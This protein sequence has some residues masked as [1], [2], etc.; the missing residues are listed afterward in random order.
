M[1][2]TWTFTPAVPNSGKAVVDIHP[3][4]LP[5]AKGAG[6]GTPHRS[7]AF[8]AVRGLLTAAGTYTT[9][10]DSPDAALAAAGIGLVEA[11][12][13]VTD[14]GA[15]PVA[16]PAGILRYNTATNKAMLYT[17]AAV[18]LAAAAATTG[19]FEVLVLGRQG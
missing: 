4:I 16:T 17:S 11:I 13:V 18:E 3:A 9:G 10:G 7:G 14:T 19:S 1:A 6:A 12:L 2:T 15:A 8:R 5:I